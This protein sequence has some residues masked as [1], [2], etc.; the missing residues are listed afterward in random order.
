[1]TDIPLSLQQLRERLDCAHDEA[2]EVI[3]ESRRLRLKARE[4]VD[5]LRRNAT[6]GEWAKMSDEPLARADATR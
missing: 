4:L 3:A 6:A 1:M 5:R 2:R